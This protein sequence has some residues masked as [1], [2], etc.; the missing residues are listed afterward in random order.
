MPLPN[1]PEAGGVNLDLDPIQILDEMQDKMDALREALSPKEAEAPPELET[2]SD[3]EVMA[4]IP[5]SPKAVK[6]FPL[7]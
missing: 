2:Q 5:P 3:D 7:G 1:M 6:P 4:G